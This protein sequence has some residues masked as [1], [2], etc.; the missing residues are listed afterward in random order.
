[1]SQGTPA[2]IAEVLARGD[3]ASIEDIPWQRL[4]R[5]NDNIPA[6]PVD[7]RPILDMEFFKEVGR[8]KTFDATQVSH[9]AIHDAWVILFF[10]IQANPKGSDGHK[11]VEK[12]SRVFDTMVGRKIG[13]DCSSRTALLQYTVKGSTMLPEKLHRFS[14]TLVSLSHY[15]SFPWHGI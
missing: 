2:F 1:L 5:L 7:D 10:M 9:Q 15:F 4:Q 8:Y 3:P 12:R 14:R 13:A 11:S 6:H